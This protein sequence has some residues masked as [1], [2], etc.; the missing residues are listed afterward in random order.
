MPREPVEEAGKG[1]APLGGVGVRNPALGTCA[2]ATAMADARAAG[3]TSTR[4]AGFAGRRG[5]R[6]VG[7]VRLRWPVLITPFTIAT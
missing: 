5:R 1:L 6:H 2:A 7:E 4:S 3:E